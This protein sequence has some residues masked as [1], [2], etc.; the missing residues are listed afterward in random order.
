MMVVGDGLAETVDA[1]ALRMADI[2]APSLAPVAMGIRARYFYR[3]GNLGE[4]NRFSRPALSRTAP[5]P[6]PLPISCCAPSAWPPK[7]LGEA[8][9]PL[10]V[11]LACSPSRLPCT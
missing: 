7:R 6:G 2:L 9:R 4:A 10:I 5:I 3:Q 1:E 11:C 8:P